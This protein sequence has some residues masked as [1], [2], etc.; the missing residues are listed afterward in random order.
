MARALCFDMYGTLCDTTTVTTRLEAELDASGAVVDGVEAVWRERQLRYSTHAALMD[1]YEPFWD[2][3][4]RG[5]DYALAVYGLDPDSETRRR[6]LEAYDELEPFP[7]AETALRRLSEAGRELVVL[8]NGNPAMLERLAENAGLAEHLDGI[9]SA[10]EATT[11]K[12]DPAVYER[13]GARLD[14]SLDDCRLVSSNA[15]DVAGAGAAGMRTTWVNRRNDP[16]EEL[17]ADPDEELA[18]LAELPD[19]V[20]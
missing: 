3:T 19:T 15:W 9:V 6:I 10:D 8:S 1:A 2:L 14:R 11:F 5:L 18:S 17:G 12:P 4:S 20:V 13:A 7:D 16:P